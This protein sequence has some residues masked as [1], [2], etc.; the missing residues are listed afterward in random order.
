M[1]AIRNRRSVREFTARTVDPQTIERLLD[2]A[3][4][5][6]NHR[7]TQ[8]W[9]F[10][11]L[12]PVA[13]RA[14]GAVLGGRKARKIED[15]EAA[16]A[17]LDKVTA[18]HGNLPAMIVFAMVEDDNP[19]TREENYAAVMMS[20]QNFALAAAA[21]GLGTHIKTGAVMQDPGARA[22]VGVPDGQKIVAVVELGE[23]AAVP[24]PK[25][26]APASQHTTFLD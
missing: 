19:E 8:P 15:P 2:A 25:N 4:L 12:G 21:E 6:P 13:R 3:A 10:Y 17:V 7:M 5:A 18:A 14:Y 24:S 20:V 16:R 1:Q 23:P 26:R 11:V 22:A 9:R